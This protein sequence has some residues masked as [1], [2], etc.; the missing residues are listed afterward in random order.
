MSID[1]GGAS[2]AG[3]RVL[4]SERSW[5][6]RDVALSF[7][8]AYLCFAGIAA[9][10]ESTG[11]I[12]GRVVRVDGEG[13]AGATVVLNETAMSA[14]TADDGRFSFVHVDAGTYSISITLP[15]G[16]KLPI[17]DVRLA[18]DETKTLTDVVVGFAAAVIV[19]GASG[20]AEGIIE[21][22]AAA[23]IVDQAE[24]ERKAP[25][26]QVAKLLEFTPGAQVTQGG[27]WDFNIGTRGFNRAISRRVAVLLDGR[28]LALPFFGYQ[29]WPAFS[30]PLD[31][32]SS[33]ELVRGP[34]AALYGPNAS[35]G[36][37]NLTS[38]DPKFSPGGMVRAA[39]GQSN[40]VNLETRWAGK[41]GNEWYARVV[42]GFRRSDGF[43]VSRVN[44]PEY[45][46]AC[47]PGTFGDCLPREIVPI[48]GENAQIFFGGIRLDKYLSGGRMFTVEGGDAQ[49]GF[50]VFQ[51]TAQRA[52]AIGRDG[53]RPWAR[54]SGRGDHFNVAASYDGYYEPSGYVGLTSGTVFNSDSRR[55]QVDGR[56]NWSFRQDSV[57][58]VAGATAATE[59]MDSF[60][61][62][63]G[64]Q[65]FLFRPVVEDKQAL[66][67]LGSWNITRQVKVLLAA[68]GDWSSLHAFQLSPKSSVTYSF[69]SDQS[70][71]LTYSRAFQ[72][73]NSLE[74][75]LDAPVAPPV[76]L[77]ALNG[78]C[79]P[80]G[81]NCKFGPTPVLALG[82]ENLGVETV[83]TW[84]VGYKGVLAEKALVTLDYYRT[85]SANVA[86]SLLPQLGTALG[87]INP[88]FGPWEGP[89]GLPSAIVDQI[90]AL[91]PLLSNQIDGSN[92]LAAASYTNFG[93]VDIQGID[94]GLSYFL[95]SGWR[96]TASYSWF[97]FNPL[98][99]PAGAQNLLLPNT[100]AHTV[101]AGVAYDR[102]RIAASL[103]ARWVDGFR[104]ADGYF[105]GNVESYTTVDLTATYPLTAALGV[106][107]NVSNLLDDRH[108][109]TFGGALLRRR[110]LVSLQYKW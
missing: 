37:I 101:S 52:K 103:D 71:R 54:F 110:A 98:D 78:F 95:P 86:T 84:E 55:L 21:A 59:N 56:T 66:F 70:I 14:V 85:H 65:T 77:S 105:L 75:F 48:D 53:K 11:R 63:V 58:V 89:D 51:V 79:A 35:G 97:D 87:R 42:G 24:I 43:A 50:G 7:A 1:L 69:A 2:A 90:R 32:L 92:I 91:V 67:G 29:G 19:R 22:P 26:G 99:S 88:R 102:N 80:F 64:G 17:A 106:S 100:P 81:V 28:D 39:F 30:F 10:E 16:V 96:S 61:P 74:Y 3:S 82:N 41:L 45:S 13:V 15:Q 68:R 108:W 34:S 94:L 60:N 57:Q 83:R 8:I 109:E 49:G 46:V 27:L 104:W 76:D 12:E 62:K 4:Q 40:T 36:V 73:P 47:A 72:V 93:A 6:M 38:K 20:R 31:D 44:G 107:L 9:G 33:V 18:S 23:T 25:D 5:H